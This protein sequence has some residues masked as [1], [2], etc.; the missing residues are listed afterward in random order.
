MTNQQQTPQDQAWERL[1]QKLSTPELLAVLKR[2]AN[3]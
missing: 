2:L 1:K 3:K